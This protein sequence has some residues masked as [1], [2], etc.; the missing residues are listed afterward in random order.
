MGAGWPNGVRDNANCGMA[1]VYC[2]N[3]GM[4]VRRDGRLNAK[5]AD[6]R[7]DAGDMAVMPENWG[8]WKCGEIMPMPGNA[9]YEGNG[10]L[11]CEADLCGSAACDCGGYMA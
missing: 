10:E 9:G 3:A 8:G 5:W 6:G 7:D 1:G 4:H 11:R 2:R